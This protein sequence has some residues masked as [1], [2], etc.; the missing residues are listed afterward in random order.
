MES[1]SKKIDL[2][3]PFE[4]SI[5]EEYEI[6]KVYYMILNMCYNQNED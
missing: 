6:K 2:E 1:S 5:F 3:K 4:L